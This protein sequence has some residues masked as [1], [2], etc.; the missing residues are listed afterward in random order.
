MLELFSALFGP[1][2]SLQIAFAQMISGSEFTEDQMEPLS[3][4]IWQ[5][6]QEISAVMG[7]GAEVQLQAL[8][9]MIVSWAEDYDAIL[10][11]ALAEP[12]VALGTI[13]SCSDNP[14]GAFARSGHFTPFTAISNATGS[15][16]ISVPLYQNDELGL[17][18]A[19][20]FIGR[21]ESEG[22]LLALSTQLENALPWVG[23]RA[24]VDAG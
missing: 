24:P 1:M 7:F 10:C 17:P 6:S 2:I 4:S 5:Q 16:A 22:L 3:W 19:V 15:P 11:P 13:D 12:P 14:M 20:Q 8:A 9:R 23:R 21:P 18:L